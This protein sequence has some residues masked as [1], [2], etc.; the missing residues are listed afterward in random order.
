MKPDAWWKRERMVN[1]KETG[2]GFALIGLSETGDA[3]AAKGLC[4]E[5]KTLR[6][7]FVK[8]RFATLNQSFC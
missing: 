6:Q 7:I 4:Q 2:A 1:V 3:V 8:I 5:L